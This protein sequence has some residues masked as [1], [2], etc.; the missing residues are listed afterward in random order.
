M[1]KVFYNSRIA[2]TLLHF[3]E[4]HTITLGAFVFSKLKQTE[5]PQ[6]VRNHECTHARQWIE[7]T[8]LAGIVL[9]ALV[10]TL[11]ISP[12]WLPTAGL[13]FYAW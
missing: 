8:V 2:K 11:D 9:L 5:M 7:L 1:K 6:H 13:W 3:S 4:C 12:W 10:L